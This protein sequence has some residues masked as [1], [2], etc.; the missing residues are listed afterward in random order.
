MWQNMFRTKYPALAYRKRYRCPDCSEY[1]L[2]IEHDWYAECE[3][4][5][6]SIELAEVIFGIYEDNNYEGYYTTAEI[7]ELFWDV[8]ETVEETMDAVRR[9]NRTESLYTPDQID[10]MNRL[11]VQSAHIDE[12]LTDY[13]VHYY[14]VC[15]ELENNRS[16]L[17]DRDIVLNLIEDT[18]FFVN[19]ALNE[20]VLYEYGV[21]QFDN[22]KTHSGR[23]FFNNLK[24]HIV[25]SWERMI[26]LL[27][28][29]FDVEF[30][31]HK[32]YENSFNALLKKL[33][34]ND[35]FIQTKAYSSMN[36]LGK[37]PFFKSISETRQRNDHE[38]SEHMDRMFEAAK[39][40]NYDPEHN[41]DRELAIDAEAILDNIESLFVLLE[42]AVAHFTSKALSDTNTIEVPSV[43]K[44]AYAADFDMLVE[45]LNRFQ[46]L[47]FENQLKALYDGGVKLIK[48]IEGQTIIG[49]ARGDI[50]IFKEIY[51][52]HVDI[53]FRLHEVTR[54]F[55]D[56]GRCL[57]GTI[58]NVYP[59]PSFMVNKEYFVYAAL[60]RT[61]ACC[62]KL[63]KLIA[64]LF[65]LTP[66]NKIYFK[67]AVEL[68]RH[69]EALQSTA[70][71]NM[72]TELADKESFAQLSQYRNDLFHNMRPGKLYGNEGAEIH[73]RYM[74]YITFE[75]S[76]ALLQISNELNKHIVS[77]FN[78]KQR[79]AVKGW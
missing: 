10:R 12:L 33:M 50:D 41:F 35:G 46:P 49:G 32:K 26:T 3:D 37:L 4:G 72:I 5:C 39:R 61:Y 18:H 14:R 54:C 36:G 28:L 16:A 74:I 55:F 27:A 23:F 53:V 8:D 1:T 24:F 15:P 31:A 62:D 79:T 56:Y 65:L 13:I 63:G 57:N 17:N 59:F 40:N 44:Q 78:L 42:E 76:D 71:L 6:E 52:Y 64:K 67:D 19:K 11:F 21:D 66:A 43:L 69:N 51:K 73:H 70:L 77:R 45:E 9:Q 20:L 68:A 22:E 25:C 38:F 48:E 58:H 29:L 60:Y 75:I 47:T 30:S 7:K 34:N 2:H